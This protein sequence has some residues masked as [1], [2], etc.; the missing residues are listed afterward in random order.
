M[1]YVFIDSPD[2]NTINFSEVL[3]DNVNTLRYNKDAT[4]TFIK[5]NGSKPSFVGDRTEY[6]YEQILT[7]LATEE[8]GE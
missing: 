7:I 4:K 5:Y 8:W 3:E 1:K 2:I 6:T